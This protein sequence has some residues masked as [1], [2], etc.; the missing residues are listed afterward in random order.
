MK[1]LNVLLIWL[2]LCSQAF[3][4]WTFDGSSQDVGVTD[5]ALLDFPDGDW[6][7]AGWFNVA[8]NVGTSFNALVG[9]GTVS[10]DPSFNVYCREASAATPNAI[11]VNYQDAEGDPAAFESSTTPCSTT[12]TWQHLIL[13]RSS[14]T[15]TLYIG[16]T[17]VATQ[18][19]ANI[20]GAA[21]S[22]TWQFGNS[23]T[24]THFFNGSLADWGR[25]DR[26]ISAGERA[27][28]QNFSWN[29]LAGPKFHWPMIRDFVEVRSGLTV[30]NNGATISAGPPITYCH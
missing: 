20:D 22:D 17:S 7:V 9:W 25:V 2:L 30:T 23:G 21:V 19:N 24:A 4:A 28:L 3:G 12:A 29:C 26:V 13:T 15:L 18:T 14:T 27:T 5:N 1:M 8:S 10:A 16:N 6:T 11:S